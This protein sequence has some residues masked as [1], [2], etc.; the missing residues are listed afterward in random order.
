MVNKQSLT[1]AVSIFNAFSLHTVSFR[2][3][4]S[5]IISSA[6]G[7]LNILSCRQSFG[8]MTDGLL[9]SVTYLGPISFILI[10]CLLLHISVA[11]FYTDGLWSTFPSVVMYIFGSGGKITCGIPRAAVHL[12]LWTRGEFLLAMLLTRRRFVFRALSFRI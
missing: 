7:F 12:M 4:F 2:M 1:S 11:I 5:F 6:C 9:H 10:S 8:T 3:P